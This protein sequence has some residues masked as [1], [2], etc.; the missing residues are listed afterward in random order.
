MNL[1]K[2]EVMEVGKERGHCCVEVGDSCS[3]L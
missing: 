3:R 1:E 2:T